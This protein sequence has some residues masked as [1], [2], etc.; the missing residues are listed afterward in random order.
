M[1]LSS[2]Y[3]FDESTKSITYVSSDDCREDDKKIVDKGDTVG[4]QA[5]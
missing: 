2:Y 3:R 4:N 1:F 5:S